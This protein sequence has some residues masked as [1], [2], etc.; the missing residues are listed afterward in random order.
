MSSLSLSSDKVV[1]N[2]KT[3]RIYVVP[4][5]QQSLL[6]GHCNESLECLKENSESFECLKEK[7][8]SRGIAM[9]SQGVAIG[10]FFKLSSNKSTLNG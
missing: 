7:S 1:E 10:I 4:D 6:K 2:S 8:E 3:E 9:V 5:P